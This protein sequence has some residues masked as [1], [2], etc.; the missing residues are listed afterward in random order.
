MLPQRCRHLSMTCIA[1]LVVPD[2]SVMAMRDI[3]IDERSVLA[4]TYKL[5]GTR[6]ELTG[7]RRVKLVHTTQVGDNPCDLDASDIGLGGTDGAVWQKIEGRLQHYQEQL[8]ASKLE[9]SKINGRLIAEVPWS[10]DKVTR[11]VTSV[12]LNMMCDTAGSDDVCPQA[13]CED[14]RWKGKTAED[15]FDVFPAFR[16]VLGGRRLGRDKMVLVPCRVKL[17]NTCE[18]F[19]HELLGVITRVL[20]EP[21]VKNATKEDWN[22][23]QQAE[24]DKQLTSEGEFSYKHKAC[25]AYKEQLEKLRNGAANEP[26]SALS[27]SSGEAANASTESLKQLLSNDT[28]ASS[29]EVVQSDKTV[30]TNITVQPLQ[31]IEASMQATLPAENGATRRLVETLKRDVLPDGSV[32]LKKEIDI[33][34]PAAGS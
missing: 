4:G 26:E 14:E 29:F 3:F 21:A 23:L 8:K 7:V 18:S 33:L 28:A 34:P 9:A 32:K 10:P 12:M 19:C 13:G 17:G 22:L 6:S 5:A 2:L 30:I 16:E 11:P 24:L 20:E 15:Y 31:D 1:A 25:S 27:R